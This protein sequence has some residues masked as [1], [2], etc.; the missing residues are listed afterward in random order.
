MAEKYIAVDLN[1]ENSE[2]IAE[3]LGNKTCKKILN[4]LSEKELSEGDIAKELK[5]PLNTVDY[6]V[7]KLADSGLIDKAK[8]FFWSVKGK[9]I[10]TYK[11]ANKLIVISPKK[12]NVYSKLKGIVPVILISGILTAFVAW[13]SKVKFFAGEGLQKVAEAGEKDLIAPA[14]QEAISKGMAALYLNPWI[15]FLIG[16][17]MAIIAFILWNWKK[18]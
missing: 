1:D 15:W 10:G 14:T 13:Y 18:L 12:S 6:N 4:L 7:K 17:L 9:K 2:R 16:S 5:I 3:I 11:I 8:N